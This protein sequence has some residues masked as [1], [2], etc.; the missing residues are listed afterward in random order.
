MD[1]SARYDCRCAFL[2]IYLHTSVCFSVF[3]GHT[4]HSLYK[5]L[6]IIILLCVGSTAPPLV[7]RGMYL[8]YIHTH[9]AP[10]RRGKYWSRGVRLRLRY[11]RRRCKNVLIGMRRTSFPALL[12]QLYRYYIIL[13]RQRSRPSC[14]YTEESSGETNTMLHYACTHTH[15]LANIRYHIIFVQYVYI[16]VSICVAWNIRR[17]CKITPRDIIAT[18]VYIIIIYCYVRA[19]AT[20]AHHRVSA[21]VCRLIGDSVG[22]ARLREIVYRYTYIGTCIII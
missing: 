6:Y 22:G 10:P 17:V 16:F 3:S 14:I 11:R 15:M 5:L 20:D 1:L 2:S 18:H 12:L 21:V 9:T 8:Y 4:H 19:S 7:D 13:L